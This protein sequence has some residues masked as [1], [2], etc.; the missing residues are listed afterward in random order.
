M[1]K[2]QKLSASERL[3][4]AELVKD[5][6]IRLGTRKSENKGFSDMPL[7]VVKNQTELF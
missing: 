6:S 5:Q 3:L 1:A 2:K 7:F 4:V